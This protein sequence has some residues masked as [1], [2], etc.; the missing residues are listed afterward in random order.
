VNCRAPQILPERIPR[1]LFA[2]ND[3]L[4]TGR[5]W[6]HRLPP[7]YELSAAVAAWAREL[8]R[9]P[10][11]EDDRDTVV[12]WLVRAAGRSAPVLRRAREM[13]EIHKLPMPGGSLVPYA[14]EKLLDEAEGSNLAQEE[15]PQF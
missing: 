4:K 6:P 2:V 7:V 9:D 12:A 15:P 5:L 14:A 3:A 11:A 10:R 13:N 8:A 1:R